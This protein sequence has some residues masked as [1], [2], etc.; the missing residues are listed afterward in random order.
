LGE[1]V[2]PSEKSISKNALTAIL[3]Y[4]LSQ[5]ENLS[6]TDQMLAASE[7]SAAIQTIKMASKS[8]QSFYKNQTNFYKSV[9]DELSASGLSNTRSTKFI[10]AGIM[11]CIC[12]SS[13]IDGLQ[14]VLVISVKNWIRMSA[15]KI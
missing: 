13:E 14:D 8:D 1:I 2:Q 3:L 6:T 12:K 5:L 7:L 4:E 9:K 11:E 10:V 15:T